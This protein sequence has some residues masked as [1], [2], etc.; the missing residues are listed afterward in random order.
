MCYDLWKS[1]IEHVVISPAIMSPLVQNNAQKLWPI[2]C[3]D[4][5]INFLSAWLEF[6]I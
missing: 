5:D 3:Q 1:W 2:V 6:T 4:S